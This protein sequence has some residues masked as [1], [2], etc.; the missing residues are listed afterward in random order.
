MGKSMRVHPV[1]ALVSILAGGQIAGFI[2]II[3]GVP[4]AVMVQE[5]FNYLAERRGRRPTLDI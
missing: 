4:I 2:G 3:L 1:V 5:I